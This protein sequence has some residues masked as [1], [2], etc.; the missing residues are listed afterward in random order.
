MTKQVK[1]TGQKAAAAELKKKQ[2]RAH[3]RASL[4]SSF[5]FLIKAYRVLKKDELDSPKVFTEL[6]PNEK[7]EAHKLYRLK[8]IYEYQD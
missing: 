8:A 4:R 2:E 1:T 7:F 5:P 6:F 3:I